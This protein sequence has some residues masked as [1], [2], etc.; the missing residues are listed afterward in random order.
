MLYGIDS[1]VLDSYSSQPLWKFVFK[2]IESNETPRKKLLGVIRKSCLQGSVLNLEHFLGTSIVYRIATYILAFTENSRNLCS[3]LIEL[4]KPTVYVRHLP[5]VVVQDE[6]LIGRLGDLNRSKVSQGY[7]PHVH[8]A[9]SS[10]GDL[11]LTTIHRRLQ[12]LYRR[13]ITKRGWS[14]DKCWANRCKVESRV[15]LLI[16]PR[17][18]LGQCL[19]LHV[20]HESFGTVGVAPRALVVH[21]RWHRRIFLGGSQHSRARGRN[22]AH[23]H[24]VLRACLHHGRGT[25]DGWSHT[26]SSKVKRRGSMNHVRGTFAG[27]YNGGLVVEIGTH[28]LEVGE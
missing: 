4:G 24:P 15:C 1:I 6:S 8:K 26:I 20:I 13:T 21:C 28:E 3:P 2:K 5:L 10:P 9:T 7:V 17:S 22:D 16:I 19:A 11:G 23:L 25:R 14:H 18:L 27:R 12:P